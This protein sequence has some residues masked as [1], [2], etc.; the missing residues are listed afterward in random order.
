MSDSKT[1]VIER[2]TRADG[3]VVTIPEELF[4][5]LWAGNGR[6]PL[7]GMDTGPLPCL[8]APVHVEVTHS[9][10]HIEKLQS[11]GVLDPA[12]LYC[13]KAPDSDGVVR[14]IEGQACW[15]CRMDDAR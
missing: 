2:G 13:F 10:G 7:E 1:Y 6:T 14:A 4:T 15:S 11:P 8:T 5:V 3:N 9:C 12:G